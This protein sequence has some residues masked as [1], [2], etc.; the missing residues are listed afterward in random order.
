MPVAL[1]AAVDHLR[2][3][4]VYH[5]AGCAAQRA[6]RRYRVCRPEQISYLSNVILPRRRCCCR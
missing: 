2:R 5:A 3:D 1:V 4:P 6:P